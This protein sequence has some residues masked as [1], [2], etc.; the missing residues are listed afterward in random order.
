MKLVQHKVVK[1]PYV[2]VGQVTTCEEYVGCFETE[3]GY[4]RVLRIVFEAGFFTDER[5]RACYDFGELVP[6]KEAVE[7]FGQ[8]IAERLDYDS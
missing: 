1:R 8:A 4:F 6:P 5:S 3:A 2:A 7:L